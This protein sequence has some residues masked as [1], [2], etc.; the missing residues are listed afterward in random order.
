MWYLVGD[1]RLTRVPAMAGSMF[2]LVIQSQLQSKVHIKDCNS[3]FLVI[4]SVHLTD[5]RKKT[6]KHPHWC[7]IDPRGYRQGLPQRI[8]QLYQLLKT[9]KPSNS[10]E[11]GKSPQHTFGTINYAAIYPSFLIGIF[12]TNQTQL[13]GSTHTIFIV[14]RIAYR[15]RS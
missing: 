14:A 11:H 12:A 4:A 7:K 2:L 3:T 10:P 5:W 9:S 8:Q 1:E 15:G 13:G 6:T